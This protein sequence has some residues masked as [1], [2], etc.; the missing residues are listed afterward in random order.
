MVLD[1]EP[2]TK[3]KETETKSSAEG[4]FKA[5]EAADQKATEQQSCVGL[6]L[7]DKDIFCST[8][9]TLPATTNRTGTFIYSI[10]YDKER[11]EEDSEEEVDEDSEEEEVLA[12]FSGQRIIQARHSP[13]IWVSSSTQK[14]DLK[15][16]RLNARRSPQRTI[17]ES[18][19]AGNFKM[20]FELNRKKIRNM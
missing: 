9:Q 19:F 2:N 14:T 5:A 15:Q 4:L 1:R 10:F 16:R 20:A 17:I 8:E 13:P 6:T 3:P 18:G 11:D 12:R 7:C